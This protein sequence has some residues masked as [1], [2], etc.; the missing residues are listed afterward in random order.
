MLRLKIYKL[1]GR[2]AS[3]LQRSLQGPGSVGDLP[4]LGHRAALS[5]APGNFPH[6][7][8]YLVSSSPAVLPHPLR[9]QS[10]LL[11]QPNMPWKD[12]SPLWRPGLLGWNFR[13]TGKGG[14]SVSSSVSS[15]WSTPERIE[16]ISLSSGLIS[17]RERFALAGTPPMHPRVRFVNCLPLAL[18][19]GYPSWAFCN[20]PWQGD[21]SRS[22]SVP[23][24][25]KWPLIFR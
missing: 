21:L 18:L 8:L 9:E 10:Q 14:H 6:L 19:S 1:L 17:D 3:A 15:S 23:A 11:W 24:D 5:L 16:W 7:P 25:H 2:G 13:E 22:Q 20:H 4:L 12:A